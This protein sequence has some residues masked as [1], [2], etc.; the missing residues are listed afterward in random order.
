MPLIEGVAQGSNGLA[1]FAHADDGTLVYQAGGA[2]ARE[3]RTLVWVDRNGEEEPV[4][5][6]PRQYGQ[7]QLSPDGRR[8]VVDT[9]GVD[10]LFLYDLDTEVEEQ[11]TFSDGLDQAPI[12]SPDGSQIV[13]ASNRDDPGP[14]SLYV[15]PADGSGTAA[16]LTTAPF[17]QRPVDWTDDGGTVVF[18]GQDIMTLRLGADAEPETLLETDAL[19]GVYRVSPNGRWIAYRSNESGVDE[20]YVRP[21]P[22]LS[23]GGQRLIS[24]GPG[25]D[26]IWGPDGQELFYLTPDAVMVVPV[27]AG[28]TFQRGTPRQLFS[29]DAYYEGLDINWDISPDGQRFLM[30][31]REAANETASGEINVVQNWFEELKRLVPT[32]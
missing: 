31:K 15:K 19:E 22:D 3:P 28:D 16:R 17:V 21:F 20:I 11:F 24:D 29:M 9:S 25:D 14:T 12:W 30:V 4:G 8:L 2:Q 7:V 23:S 6:T 5:M 27:E 32:E 26:P 10:E 13:F 1:Q 18:G